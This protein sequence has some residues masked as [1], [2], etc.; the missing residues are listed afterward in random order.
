MSK[1]IAQ[2]LVELRGTRT[3]E[4]VAAAVGVTYNAIQAYELGVRVPKDSIKLKLAKYYNTT[5]DAL[6]FSSELHV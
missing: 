5:V 4:E 1:R 3:R 6:F 2:K